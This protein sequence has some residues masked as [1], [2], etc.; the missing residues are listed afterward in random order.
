MTNPTTVTVMDR[1]HLSLLDRAATLSAWAV[2][3]A[4]FATVGWHAL[5]PDDPLA[6]VAFVG[7]RG[8]LFAL[9]EVV[10]LA[11]LA[12]GVATVIAGRKLADIGAFSV[13]LGLAVASLRGGTTAWLLLERADGGGGTSAALALFFMFDTLVWL[14]V[15]AAS[16]LAGAAVLRWCFD[17]PAPS[18][19]DEMDLQTM[20]YSGGAGYDVPGVSARLFG[21]LPGPQT[22]LADGLRH[23]LIASGVGLIVMTLVSGGLSFRSIQHGQVCFVVAA[24]VFIGVDVAYRLVPVRSA[25]WAV[26]AVG[27]MAIT[28]YA[29]S[30]FRAAPPGLPPNIPSTHFMRVLPVQFVSVGTAAA[31]VAF[32]YAYLPAPT[33]EVDRLSHK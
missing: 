21:S 1:P 14:V 32:W 16:F 12:A 8:A 13:A 5:A 15:I 11:A 9:L 29:W 27:V 18:Q 19:V 20:A 25:L 30:A 17:P 3:I 6:P 2:G 31:V 10:A 7:H 33:V 28:G 26:L 23:T 22:P 24:S 4:M